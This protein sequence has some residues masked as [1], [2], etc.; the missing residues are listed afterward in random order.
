MAVNQS[1]AFMSP[2]GGYSSRTTTNRSVAPNQSYNYYMPGGAPRTSSGSV[3]GAST[4]VGQGYSSPVQ[5]SPAPQQSGDP[6]ANLQPQGPSQEEIDA[7]FNPILDVYNQAESTLRGQLPG[8][9]GE[10]EQQALASRGLLEGQRTS[11]NQLLSGQ[12]QQTRQT[13]QSQTAQQRQILQELAQANQQRFGG[14]SSAGLAAGEL[15]GRE[16][17]RGVAGIGQNAQQAF[18][19]I[20]EQRQAVDRDFQQGLQQLEVNKQ[21]A[22]NQINR[23]FQDKLLE[24]NARRGETQAAKAAARMEAL[25]QLRNAAFQINVQRAQFQSQLEQQRQANVSQLDTVQNSLLQYTGQGQSGVDQFASTT[26][27]SIPTVGQGQAQTNTPYTGRI[28]EREEFSGIIG[29]N[30]PLDRLGQQLFNPTGLR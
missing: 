4:G 1:Y 6:F 24:I 16:F 22:V 2:V 25:Q 20:G 7:Q 30:N 19:Q 9:I 27:S 11:A 5:Q 23:T 28:G 14:A 17:Q 29:V 18:Q 21:Q 10:A 26:P 15:Q 8:L 3:L 13:Q 12:E